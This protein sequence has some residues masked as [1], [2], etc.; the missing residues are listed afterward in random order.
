LDFSVTEE[1]WKIA[2]KHQ[3]WAVA[4]GSLCRKVRKGDFIVLY[5]I[6]IGSFCTIMEIIEDWILSDQPI[7]ADE[8]EAGKIKYPY[9]VKTRIVQEGLADVKKILPKLS[10][11]ENKRY[12]G[13]YFKGTPANMGKPIPESDYRIIYETMR[14]N[15]LPKDISELLKPRKKRKILTRKV[16]EEVPI[17]PSS[18]KHNEIRDMIF[19]I[20]KFE[21]K[22]SEIEY[23][24]NNWRLDVIWKRIRAGNPTHVFE[25]QISGNFYEALTKLKHAWDLWN[26]KPF[27]VT[28][29]EYITQAERLLEGSFHEMKN[30]ARI[31]NWKKIVKLYQ[32]LKEV[33]EI[34]SEIRL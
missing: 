11:I 24:I 27:L 32:L 6:G 1:N 28:T 31:V 19:E 18:P 15:P 23:P 2:R 5:V 29:E 22:I 8:K 16:K 4:R 21:N 7:W 17:T 30:D 9:Q 10:F 12:W 33:N 14:S 34:K 26:S 13:L 25:V 3:V 20:G